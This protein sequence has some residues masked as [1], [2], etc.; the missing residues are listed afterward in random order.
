MKRSSS[1]SSTASTSVATPATPAATAAAAV[2]PLAVCG[3]RSACALIRRLDAKDPFVPL[4]HESTSTSSSAS[5]PASTPRRAAL[6]PLHALGHGVGRSALDVAKPVV[7]KPVHV[8]PAA[9]TAAVIWTNGQRQVIG[10]GADVQRRRRRSSGSS[11]SRGRRCASRSSAAPSPAESTRSRVRKGHRVKLANT[12]TGVEYRLLF[13][14]GTTEAP[15]VIQPTATRPSRPPRTRRPEAEARVMNPIQRKANS[16]E[17]SN[18]DRRD[19]KGGLRRLRRPRLLTYAAVARACVAAVSVAAGAASCAVRRRQPAGLQTLQPRLHDSRARTVGARRRPDVLADAV[20]R[21][22]SRSAARRA[23]S[24][25]SR[26]ASSSAPTTAS[27]GRAGRSR[28]RRPPFRSR[29]RGSRATRRRC[30]GTSAR[31]R[32]RVPRGATPQASTCAGRRLPKDEAADESDPAEDTRATSAGRRR[33]ATGYDVW[34]ANLGDTARSISTITT[35]ADEREYYTSCAPPSTD[36]E[37]RVRARR[38]V[39]GKTAEQPAARVVRSVERLPSTRRRPAYSADR[40]VRQTSAQDGVGSSSCPTPGRVRCARAH[41]GVLSSRADGRPSASRLHRDRQGLRQHRPRRLD[42]RRHG[43]RTARQRAARSQPET[44][45]DSR[46][47]AKVPPRRHE[48]EHVPVRRRAV[49]T[50]ETAAGRRRRPGGGAAA[51]SD[52]R[53]RARRPRDLRDHGSEARP[54]STSG[55]RLGTGVAVTT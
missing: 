22:G 51:A 53:R 1:S 43:L 9:P 31:R 37:W 7:T 20:V 24:S 52:D 28:L 23:T 16:V 10:L 50:N 38:A 3:A 47:R 13:A 12:A 19:A 34:F 4:I 6:V 25:S 48:G 54:R 55:I 45:E 2:T 21:V 27:S 49:T 17:M 15:T 18:N 36:V 35:V 32:R 39:Y 8:K 5:T 26:R 29:C 44:L 14:R 33:G 41:A 40:R 42:R 30:T 11:R 46:R